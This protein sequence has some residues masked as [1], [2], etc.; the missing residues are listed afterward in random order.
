MMNTLWKCNFCWKENSVHTTTCSYCGM[1]LNESGQRD[2]ADAK[3]KR[4]IALLK[5][6]GAAVILLMCGYLVSRWN[7]A[8]NQDYQERQEKDLVLDSRGSRSQCEVTV[9]STRRYRASIG[10]TFTVNGREY[11]SGGTP[12]PN[13]HPKEEWDESI[14]KMALSPGTFVNVEYDPQNPTLNRIEGD[15]FLANQMVAPLGV[16]QVVLIF[17][18]IM[19]AYGIVVLGLSYLKSKFSKATDRGIDL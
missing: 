18:A 6:A 10:C 19:V 15:K 13:Y 17:V 8:A 9:Y 14:R 4:L 5:I 12:P 16:I 7:K 2:D 1:S 11:Q 3:K